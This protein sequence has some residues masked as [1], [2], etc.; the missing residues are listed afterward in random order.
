MLAFPQ[1]NFG[2]KMDLCAPESSPRVHPS[3]ARQ[4][5]HRKLGIILAYILPQF[6][7]CYPDQYKICLSGKGCKMVRS[8]RHPAVAQPSRT[9]LQSNHDSML[10]NWILDAASVRP[11]TPRLFP[12]LSHFFACKAILKNVGTTSVQRRAL[13][14]LTMPNRTSRGDGVVWI[15]G[16]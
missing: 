2:C 1:I 15:P 13:R 6:P 14:M 12:R 8:H 5:L 7:T 4:H 16:G 10:Q 3:P 9:A 11:P